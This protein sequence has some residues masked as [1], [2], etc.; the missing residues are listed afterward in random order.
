V[1]GGGADEVFCCESGEEETVGWG[2]KNVVGLA[3]LGSMK[4]LMLSAVVNT[5]EDMAYC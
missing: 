3:K 1:W 4:V 2:Q 5:L